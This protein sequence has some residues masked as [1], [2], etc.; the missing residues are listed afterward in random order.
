MGRRRRRK[1]KQFNLRVNPKIAWWSSLILCCL[2][3]LVGLGYAI[4]N[5]SVFKVGE[6]DIRSNMNLSRG[7]IEKI[8]GK[9]LFSIDIKKISANLLKTNPEY[10]EIYVYREFPSSLVVEATKRIPF[11]QIKDKRYYM[12]D[13]EAVVID[14]GRP[15]PLKGLIP[16]EIGEYRRSLRKGS[17]IKSDKVEYAFDL[18]EALRGQGFLKGQD[19]VKLINAS[20]L[21][22]VYFIFLPEGYSQDQE[23]PLGQGIKIIVGKGDFPRKVKLF[24][25]LIDQELKEKMPSVNYIDLRFKRVYMDY[26][27]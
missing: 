3:L 9:S 16:L 19:Q 18:I 27:R 4:Y 24:K 8:K 10:K 1:F 26:K 12:V 6:G 13:K 25:D 17:D 20:Q 2:I 22:A 15:E 21:E 23:W 14:D 11:A 7:L 5:A